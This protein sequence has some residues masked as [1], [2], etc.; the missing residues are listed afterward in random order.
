MG[1]EE[2][3]EKKREEKKILWSLAVEL[4]FVDYEGKSQRRTVVRMRQVSEIS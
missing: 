3:G 2:R 1:K 4:C